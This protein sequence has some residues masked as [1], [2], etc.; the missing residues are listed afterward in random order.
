MFY[1]KDLK[2]KEDQFYQFYN[3]CYYLEIMLDESCYSD[4]D[5]IEF[6]KVMDDFYIID[7]LIEI[8]IK[9]DKFQLFLHFENDDNYVF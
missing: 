3:V 2:H 1:E 6:V 4:E 8:L 7:E 9:K 5:V